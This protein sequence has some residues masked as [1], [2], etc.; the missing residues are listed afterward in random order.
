LNISQNIFDA[1]SLVCYLQKKMAKQFILG[2][3][4]GIY[5]SSKYPTKPYVEYAERKVLEQLSSIRTEIEPKQ[6]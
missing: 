1:R 5:I 4:V 2:L 3:L 6:S